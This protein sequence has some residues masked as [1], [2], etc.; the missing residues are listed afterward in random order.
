MTPPSV[1]I[2]KAKATSAVAMRTDKWRYVEWTKPGAETVRE[3]YNMVQDPQ[4]NQNVAAK[5]EHEKVI[6]ALGKRLREKFPVQEFK[7][8]PEAVKGKKRKK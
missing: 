5:P 1:G 7:A 4:N 2:P 8:P 6:E 3:L